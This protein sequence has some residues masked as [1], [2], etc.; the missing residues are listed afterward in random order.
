LA[1]SAPAIHP[2]LRRYAPAKICLSRL[3]TINYCL[4]HPIG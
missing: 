1:I 2:T 4:S 3:I